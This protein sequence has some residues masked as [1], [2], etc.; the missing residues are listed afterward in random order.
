MSL[1]VIEF[2]LLDESASTE[3]ELSRAGSVAPGIDWEL[4]DNGD[5]IV[6]LRYVA[7]IQSVAQGIRIRI[8][9]FRGEWFADLNHG[10]PW[11]QDILG[12]KFDE[13][14]VRNAF[15]DMILE[16]PGVKRIVSSSATYDTAT[17]ATTINWEVESI[18]GTITGSATA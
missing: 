10:V 18:Y 9:T 8:L 6:P 11:F 15:R 5:L 16:T 7:G 1:P 3:E 17:R 2:D 14:V 4:D 13:I 12:Q